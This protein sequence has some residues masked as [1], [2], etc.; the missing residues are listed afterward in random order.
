VVDYGELLDR[1]VITV[2][3]PD[4][5]IR[6]T[7]N[8]AVH[9]DVEFLPGAFPRY[10]ERRLGQQLARLGVN[11]FIGFK[12]GRAEAYRRSYAMSAE[13]AE[14]A[15][16]PSADPRR[17]RYEEQLDQLRGEGRS[18]GGV[19]HVTT[20]GMLRWS[21][22]IRPGSIHRLGEER[23]LAEIHSAL[24]SLL[25]DR[26]LKIIMLKAEHFDLGIPAPLLERMRR[27]QALKLRGR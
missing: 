9:V 13:E 6:A 1:M 23:F 12:R 3:S 18:A 2:T 21:V 14:R 7:I 4:G 24:D 10:D 15:G 8:N 20:V 11:T 25:N 26:Q 5:N 27:L 19:I 22:E 17:A 16:R